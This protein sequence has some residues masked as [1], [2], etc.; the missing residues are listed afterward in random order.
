[1]TSEF[2]PYSEAFP[3][4][5]TI[6]PSTA[7][8]KEGLLSSLLFSEKSPVIFE[9]IFWMT[10]LSLAISLFSFTLDNFDKRVC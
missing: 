7:G 3:N 10:S 2:H 4:L 8:S 9:S 1:M 5:L 6:V